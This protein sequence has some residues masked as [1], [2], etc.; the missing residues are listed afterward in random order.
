MAYS[1]WLQPSKLSGS[2][3]DTVNVTALSDNTG[4]TAR[5]TNLTFK[6]ANVSDVVRT[7]NQAGKP[8]FVTLQSTAS[9]NKAGGT[10]TLAGTSN[11]SK[12]TFSLGSGGTLTLV[13][14]SSYTANSVSTNNGA[15]IA[16][17]PGATAEYNFSI[18]FSNIP[19]NTTINDLLA[20]VI[21]EDN[22]GHSASCTVT[23]AAGDATLSVSPASVDLA[24]NAFTEGT[25]A[26]F[27]I[28]SNTNWTVE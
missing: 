1:A 16:G 5:S 2:G 25:S 17:D 23:Q 7:V 26:S 10:L 6:G 8:E 18:T 28:T 12:L 13:L 19:E 15:A 3:N 24:W 11:S 27:T 4:R 20:Q 9:V 21:V 14:P 22:A